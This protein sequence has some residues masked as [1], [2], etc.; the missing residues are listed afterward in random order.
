MDNDIFIP[1]KF[2]ASQIVGLAK[3]AVK[4]IEANGIR[5]K[6][7][8]NTI[9]NEKKLNR[10]TWYNYA[11]AK[12][13]AELLGSTTIGEARHWFEMW[14]NGNWGPAGIVL[15]T[16]D[17][18]PEN[19]AG[20]GVTATATDRIT[21][22]GNSAL[23]IDHAKRSSFVQ[24]HQRA[25]SNSLDAEQVELLAGLVQS[26]GVPIFGTGY[27]CTRTGVGSYTITFKKPMPAGYAVTGADA[28]NAGRVFSYTTLSGSQFAVT[29]RNQAGGF[30]TE[31]IAF[32][33]IVVS[34]V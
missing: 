34:A 33:F 20:I 24:L 31:D 2:R 27:T 9:P 7:E 21:K 22:E 18:E 14:V 17:T 11:Q 6:E 30:V 8:L 23:L 28:Q 1:Y 13:R 32:S 26:N 25:N 15:E 3:V 12:I 19:K 4:F 29:M 16:T 5:L 10:L